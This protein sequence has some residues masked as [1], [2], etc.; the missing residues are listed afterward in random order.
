MGIRTVNVLP[1][2]TSLSTPMCPVE[3]PALFPRRRCPDTWRSSSKIVGALRRGMPL[4]VSASATQAAF[5]SGPPT[6]T[7][8]ASRLACSTPPTLTHLPTYVTIYA[9][10]LTV[11]RP[12]AF[13]VSGEVSAYPISPHHL[14][15]TWN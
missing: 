3:A 14:R 12:Q 11:P 7:C 8:G 10:P 15:P 1:F 2:P 13:P 5:A 6:Q 9:G 4:P